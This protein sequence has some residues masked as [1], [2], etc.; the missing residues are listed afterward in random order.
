M[1]GKNLSLPAGVLDYVKA[2]GEDRITFQPQPGVRIAAVIVPV[3]GAKPGF[4]LAGRSLREVENRID[5]LNL[6]VIAALLTTL[7][8]SLVVV[9]LVEIVLGGRRT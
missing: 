1:H 4:V 5:Q 3:S 2:N 6:Q 7:A 9:A 8:V